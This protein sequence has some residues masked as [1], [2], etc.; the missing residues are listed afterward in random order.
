MTSP[1]A[2]TASSVNNNEFWTGF[3]LAGL[4]AVLFSAKA[5]V[6]K[7]TYQH[8]VDA[9][10]VIGFRM[11]MSLP[12]FAAIGFY[13]ARKARQGR[14]PRLT[15]KECLQLVFLGFI[16]YYLSSFLDFLGLQYISAGLERLILFLSPTF[17]L[18]LSALLLNKPISGRQWLALGLSY[19]GVVFVFVQDLSFSGASVL[20]GSAFVL[21]SAFSY[22]FYLIGSGELIK[23]VG[24]TRLVAYAMSVSSVISMVHFF[25]VYGLQGLEQSAAVYQLSLIHAIVNTVVPTF[26]IMWAVARIGAP[27][28]AQLGL[29]GPVSVLFLA[30]WLLGEP[31]T[32]LQL[33]GTVITLSGAVVLSKRR[34]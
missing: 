31:I 18:L 34:V 26:M 16:G 10:T 20:V 12:F 30:A 14:L 5:I 4:G 29:L 32:T 23:R 33:L 13:Q 28:T 22:S 15:R 24:S 19:L 9:L 11:M 3:M 8:G 6:V 7:F 25:G 21:A 2:G 17:V 1:V 27:M